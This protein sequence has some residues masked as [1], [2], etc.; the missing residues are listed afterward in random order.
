MR[1]T[2]INY[3]N[4]SR[5]PV[6]PQNLYTL[7]RSLIRSGIEAR[8][9]DFNLTKKPY[10]WLQ[11]HSTDVFGLG[12]IAGYWPHQ[13][14]IKIA[15]AV[16]SHPNRKRIRFV[17]GGHGPSAAPGYYLNRLAADAVFVGAAEVSLPKWLAGPQKET[18]VPSMGYDM[19]QTQVVEGPALEVYKRV[20]FPNT[21]NDE[22]AIQILSG[23][24]CPYRCAFCYRMDK[25]FKTCLVNDIIEDIEYYFKTEGIRHFQFSD[26]LLMS[27]VKRCNQILDGLDAFHKRIGRPL[28]Y[29]CNGRLNVA[30]K[31]PV[32]LRRM[33]ETGFRYINYGCESMSQ[34]VL[35]N[36]GKQQTVEEIKAGVANTLKAGMTPGLNFMWGNPGD[37][38]KSLSGAVA[39]IKKH[40]DGAE[41]R[42]IRPVTPYPGTELF[43]RIVGLTVDTFYKEHVNSDLFSF[44]FMPMSNKAANQKLYHANRAIYSEHVSRRMGKT[45]SDMRA[46]YFGKTKPSTFRGFRDV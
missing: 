35:D 3:D 44:H 6:L 38:T 25:G 12:F 22:F 7:Q 1:V 23:R 39:F 24:G 46:F 40:A 10:S 42:T 26:E 28:A 13:E 32:L 21:R 41:L 14:A 18:I 45:I 34:A 2:L 33:A 36:I 30:A 11:Q 8:V 43:N 31:N 37:T 5:W 20:R 29:D 19:R 15:K 4:G 9:E 17:L 27:S 16:N